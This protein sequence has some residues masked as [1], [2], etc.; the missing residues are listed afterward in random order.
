MVLFL[1]FQPAYQ[2]LSLFALIQRRD[3]DSKGLNAWYWLT[4]CAV[5]EWLERFGFGAVNR[6]SKCEFEAEL[7]H[8]TTGKLCQPS[9]KWVLFSNY[10]R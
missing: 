5:V 3:A 1:I 10:G 9:S 4:R 8:A 2:L 6:R 7:R